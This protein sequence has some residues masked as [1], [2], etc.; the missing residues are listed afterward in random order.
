[1]GRRRAL[2]R[3][4][5][6]RFCATSA[7]FAFAEGQVGRAQAGPSDGQAGRRRGASALTVARE[8]QDRLEFLCTTTRTV[9]CTVLLLHM[10]TYVYTALVR[11]RS[12]LT[13]ARHDPLYMAQ[14]PVSN[15]SQSQGH[16]H[17]LAVVNS[18]A[19]SCLAKPLHSIHLV[20]HIPD[21]C[22]PADDCSPAPTLLPI[23]NVGQ[24]WSDGSIGTVPK[25]SG[26]FCRNSTSYCR[27]SSWRSIS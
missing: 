5:V 15:T 3:A 17:N 12:R 4:L 18:R 25:Q 20:G 16:A 14:I 13:T 6:D 2:R 24:A 1:V 7:G 26:S 21:A 10:P 19:G 8:S 23:P 27:I 22:L 9:L 11:S